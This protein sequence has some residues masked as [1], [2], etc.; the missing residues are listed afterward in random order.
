MSNGVNETGTEETMTDA[1]SSKRADSNS[2]LDAKSMLK[3]ESDD[4]G[5][6]KPV[7][8]EDKAEH[9]EAQQVPCN[10]EIPDKDVHISP[11]EVK[12]V[13]AAK[14]LDKAEDST[15]QLLPSKAPENEAVNV[16]SPTQSGSHPDESRS[17]KDILE[18]RTENLVSE[19]MVSVDTASK[20]AS[21]GESISEAKK[22]RRTGKKRTDDSADKDKALTEEIASKND[23]GCA[24]D[25]EARSLD[26]RE[27]LEDA[28][29][30]TD[31][32]SSLRKEDG[33]RSGRVKPTFEKDV[34]KSSSR[35]D[36]GKVIRFSCRN[37]HL[38]SVTFHDHCIL[39][40]ILYF[41]LWL[42]V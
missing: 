13:E 39:S 40:F 21:E 19:E 2:Q 17:E 34:T 25:S 32:G 35:E 7:K 14:S 22:Q 38:V 12:P 37:V 8:L 6:Q 31:Y 29:N 42:I 30:K 11:T 18:K 33:K 41:F 20:K 23:D 24:S 3:T 1:N 15:V 16:A 28:S 27:K 9:A 5:A 10:H 4:W 26:Q 36:H